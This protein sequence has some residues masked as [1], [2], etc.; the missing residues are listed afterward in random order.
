LRD[1]DVLPA[2]EAEQ[3]GVD[4]M[5]AAQSK[6]RGQT[7]DVPHR[8]DTP[9]PVMTAISTG[10]RMG[11]ISLPCRKTPAAYFTLYYQSFVPSS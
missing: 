3:G 8:T 5:G 6:Q 10:T 2:V 11:R 7:E 9:L 1:L 4:A